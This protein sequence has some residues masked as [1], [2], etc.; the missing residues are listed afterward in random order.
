MKKFLKIFFITIAAIFVILLTAPFL[1]KG[2]IMEI[3]KTELNKMLTAKVDFSDL[4][5]SFIRNFPNACIVLEDL[6]VVGTGAF[7]GDTLVAF[8]KFS[9][10]VDIKSVISMENISVKSILLDQAHLYAHIA[11]DG[12][13]NWDI[14]QP[15]DTPAE[16]TPDE[17][18]GDTNI[19]VSLS[20]FEIR[21]A[22]ITYRDDSSKM[23]ATVKDL[24]FLLKGDMS[25]DNVDLSMQLD[26]AA[27]DFLT[28]GVKLLRNARIGFAS[29]IAAD[30]KNRN[31]TLKDNQ[32]S[33]N[34]IILKFAG[35][36]N[37]PGDDIVTDITFATG[38][39]NFKSLLSLIP[40]IYMTDFAAIQTTGELTLDGYAK[41]TY[42][43]KQMPSAG[44]NLA[45][46]NAM[47]KY[48]DLPKSV[49]KIAI[50]L[51]ALY[52]GEVFDR[53]T[54]DVDKFHFE[55]AGNPFDLGL[56]IKT[57]ES[58]MQIVGE[59][60]GKIDF[61]SLTDIVPLEN[62]TL[63]GLLAC[64]LALAGR[65]STLE[66]EQYED[67]Q[68][69]GTLQLTNFDFI[70]PDFPQGVKITK[71]QLDFSPKV[72]HL[73][74]FDAIIGR[75]D[76]SLKGSL[77][78]FIPYVFKNA[79]VRGNLSLV[80]NTI[81]LNEFLSD[82]E[83][84]TTAEV[85]EADTTALSVIEVPENIDFGMN[86]KIGN[87][88]F[89]KLSITSLAGNLNVKDGKVTMDRLGMNMMDG[90]LLLSG[91][92]NTQDVKKP[93]VDFQMNISRFD[94]T[95]ALSSFTMLETMFDNPQDYV[96]KVSANLT[97]NALL[98]NQMS[99]VL[100]TILSKGQ[101][102][103]HQIEIRNSKLFGTMAD[104]LKNE[105]WRTV[106]PGDLNIKF[107]IK[108]GQLVM[109]EPVQFNVNQ[110]KVV[111]TGGQGLDMLMHYDVNASVA[112]SA[113]GATDLLNSIPGGAS[114]KELTLTGLIRGTVSKPDVKLSLGNTLN[115]ITEAVKEQVKE[116][117]TQKV[118]EVKEKVKENVTEQVDKI[119]AE[120]NKQVEAI[121]SSGKQLAETIRKEANAAADKLEKEAAS[122][123]A[124]QKAASKAAADKLRKEGESKAKQLEQE[125][126]KQANTV[127]STAQK[128]ADDLK[129]K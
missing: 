16:E 105:K 65:L 6:Q 66:K 117:V 96:G 112:A 106:S 83:E 94:I 110:A 37:M 126:E 31:F 48:P 57:P 78:N 95:S 8:K 2:K 84:A 107:E 64:D 120:A 3:A 101:L 69:D 81:D 79:T 109:V 125:T 82:S 22:C 1:F 86:V 27:L 32:F 38:K 25:L 29:E 36:V 39:T 53:T 77:E 54:L 73:V 61:N 92:Y 113:I 44:I 123:N 50:T 18:G 127:L 108:D 12:K 63:N 87:I 34:D 119:M 71:T 80:S 68:A 35:T 70:S 23:V 98:N 72:V 118:E 10:T 122:K 111:L 45:V 5:L 76:L 15:S 4:Q 93:A 128:Q 104:L 30:L 17:S 85:A 88:F 89:D 90:S 59:F 99:P 52:D 74:D 47:F 60:K 124:I 26:V 7:E 21:D 43:A 11:E 67:F 42:N 114:I 28:G 41:G 13:A 58:D 115:T 56:H 62:T 103:T 102:Q 33:L 75:T 129:N 40:A 24:D 14:M 91:E 116:A 55:M 49:D 20:K 121:R 9:I 51:K 46:D 97:L 19:R 100:N